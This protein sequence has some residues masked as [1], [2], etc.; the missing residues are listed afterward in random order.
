MLYLVASNFIFFSITNRAGDFQDTFQYCL[1]F[2]YLTCLGLLEVHK[3]HEFFTAKLACASYVIK[4]HSTTTAI[5]NLLSTRG[6]SL[7]WAALRWASILAGA[8]AKEQWGKI[9]T[10]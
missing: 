1:K 4:L 3:K 5:E 8:R 2:F 7:V 6:T 10:E 9:K